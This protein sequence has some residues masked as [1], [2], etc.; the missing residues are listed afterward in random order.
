MSIEHTAI[1]VKDRDGRPSLVKGSVQIG[2]DSKGKEIWKVLLCE[3]WE[4][5]GYETVVPQGFVPYF[6]DRQ[7]RWLRAAVGS[8]KD[9][10]RQLGFFQDQSIPF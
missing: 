6:D 7:G 10:H 8:E 1:Q 9:P 2:R 4:L 3:L 5:D